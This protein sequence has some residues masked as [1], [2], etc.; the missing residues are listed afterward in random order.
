M[1]LVTFE[2][3][4]MLYHQSTLVDSKGLSQLRR[5]RVS[6][7]TNKQFRKVGFNM[8]ISY[9]C[10]TTVFVNAPLD[11]LE[12]AA[13]EQLPTEIL[14]DPT[15]ELEQMQTLSNDVYDG[16]YQGEILIVMSTKRNFGEPVPSGFYMEGL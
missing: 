5:M 14:E 11:A 15:I 6:T 8:L 16:I 13:F 2:R 12:G 4:W 7:G 10:T 3:Q 9:K 1:S